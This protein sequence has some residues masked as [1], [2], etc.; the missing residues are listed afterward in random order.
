MSTN[1]HDMTAAREAIRRAQWPEARQIMEMIERGD[2][3]SVADQQSRHVLQRAADRRRQAAY[4]ARQKMGETFPPAR[5]RTVYGPAIEGP[6]RRQFS[7]RRAVLYGIA[8]APWVLLALILLG[9]V[10]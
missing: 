1:N 2:I 9:G 8:A 10:A 3:G 6:Y 7:W 5:P 4:E